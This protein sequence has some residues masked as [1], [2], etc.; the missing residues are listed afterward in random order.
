MIGFINI[1]CN[2]LNKLGDDLCPPCKHINDD[3]NPAKE[4]IHVLF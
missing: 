4:D 2:F 1:D 3:Q